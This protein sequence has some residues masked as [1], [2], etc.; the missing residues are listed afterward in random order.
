MYQRTQ[1]LY[2]YLSAQSSGT[3]YVCRRKVSEVTT[4]I[5]KATTIKQVAQK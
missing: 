2:L 3:L 5:L 1:L 4:A